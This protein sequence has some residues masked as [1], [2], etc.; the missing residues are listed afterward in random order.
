M[1][2][3]FTTPKAFKGHA[4][5]IQRN[6]IKSWSLLRPAPEIILFGDDNGTEEAALEVGARYAPD[7]ARS[8]GGIPLV[9]DLFRRAEQLATN[10]LL[11]YVN[12]DIVLMRD[13]MAATTTVADYDGPFLMIGHRWDLNVDDSLDFGQ[14]WEE[15]LRET[16]VRDG[17][18]H[19]PWGIDYFM[20][21]RG[22]WSEIPPFSVGRTAWDNWLI[23]G[24]RKEGAPIVDATGLVLAI[25]QNHDYGHD[26]QGE[27]GIWGGLEARRNIELLGGRDRV[28]TIEDATHILTEMGLRTRMKLSRLRR[29]L[30]RSPVTGRL[31]HL[32]ERLLA[33]MVRGFESVT[34]G[35]RIPPYRDQR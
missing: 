34:R 16:A 22:L 11:C 26:P 17:R 31:L 19:A 30:R 12:A 32:G 24:A 2:T 21:R 9:S 14:G 27:A 3:L 29:T 13:F 33:R 6:A 7:V 23:Y 5:I 1:L 15:S 20:F 35:S 10:G 25:H 4:G 8:D 18:K 28:F